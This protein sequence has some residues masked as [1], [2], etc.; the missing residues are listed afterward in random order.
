MQ[1]KL[2]SLDT[3]DELLSMRNSYINASG[4]QVMINYRATSPVAQT[5]T[6]GDFLSDQTEPDIA[7]DRIV[8]IGTSAP[9]FNDHRWATPHSHQSGTLIPLSG[10]E[11]QAHLVSQILSATL[12]QRPLIWV[13]HPSL[14]SLWIGL[15]AITGSLLAQYTNSRWRWLF[16]L[17]IASILLVTMSWQ[18]LLLGGWIPLLPSQLTLVACSSSLRFI[19]K[20]NIHRS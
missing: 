16:T 17:G 8:I 12:D 5:I 14:E 9:S 6:L 18:V 2:P 20:A 7:R 13:W 3:S 10:I 11:I 1:Q 15:W 4:H 19:L